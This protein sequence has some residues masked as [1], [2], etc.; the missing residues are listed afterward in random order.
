MTGGAELRCW[1]LMNWDL[2]ALDQVDSS[3]AY[4]YQI[5]EEAVI[6]NTQKMSMCQLDG[7]SLW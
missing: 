1:V 5:C 3:E 2:T 7:Y 6:S 4:R